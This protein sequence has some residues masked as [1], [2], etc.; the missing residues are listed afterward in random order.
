MQATLTC[1]NAANRG[2][3]NEAALSVPS[4]GLNTIQYN[5]MQYN[6]IQ[7]NTHTRACAQ[8]VDK[9]SE[10][11]LIGRKKEDMRALIVGGTKI[12]FILECHE[13]A[14]TMKKKALAAANA[15]SRR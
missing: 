2:D 15:Y 5:T 10:T 12:S 8:A 14:R 7:Y 13:G 6:T 11:V 9:R 1:V 3:I 4:L